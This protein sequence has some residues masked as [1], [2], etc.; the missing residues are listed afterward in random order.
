[1]NKHDVGDIFG[2][3]FVLAAI[4]VLERPSSIASQLMVEFT[5]GFAAIVKFAI[6]G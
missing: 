2:L 1:M 3:I 4:Y 5:N 6:A